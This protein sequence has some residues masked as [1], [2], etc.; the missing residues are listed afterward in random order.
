MTEEFLWKSD[1]DDNSNY[2][3]SDDD[4]QPVLK[5][6][7]FAKKMPIHS[8][9]ENSVITSTIND[10]LSI[11]SAETSS[12]IPVPSTTVI[13]YAD[14]NNKV[15]SASTSDDEMLAT[16]TDHPRKRK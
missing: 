3:S 12:T 4:P 8:L 5:L 6:S 13:V 16:V 15:S 7:F 1:Q 2:S 14:A 9:S 10:E 11:S